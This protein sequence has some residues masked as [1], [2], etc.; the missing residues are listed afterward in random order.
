MRRYALRQNQCE[1]DESNASDRCSSRVNT[2]RG[3]ATDSTV[4]TELCFPPLFVALDETCARWE[5]RRK[6]QKKPTHS[7]TISFS[8]ETC[9]HAPSTPDE[10]IALISAMVGA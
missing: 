3:P 5:D 7:W 2:S 6:C 8:D 9:Y 10:E 4:E 1:N